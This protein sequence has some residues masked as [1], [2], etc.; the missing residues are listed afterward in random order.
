MDLGITGH[1]MPFIGVL[2][3]IF[4]GLTYASVKR[5]PA[6]DATMVEIAEAIH[7]GAGDR[8]T[9]LRAATALKV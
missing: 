3:L 1:L 9:S 6:G 5:F 7:Q 4:A 8:V 2:G